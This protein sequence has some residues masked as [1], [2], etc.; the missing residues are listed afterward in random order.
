MSCCLSALFVSPFFII[1]GLI[2]RSLIMRSRRAAEAEKELADHEIIEIEKTAD[3]KG[4]ESRGGK[5]D[6]G[7]GCL[8]LTAHKLYFLLWMPK[9]ETEIYISAMTSVEQVDEF[10][11][12]PDKSKKKLL[13]VNFENDAGHPDSAAWLVPEIEKWEKAIEELIAK[14]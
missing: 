3:F 12:K 11:D 5:Q 13:Q 1:F 6:K 4:Q 8:A 10:M 14:R 7:K 9:V 2:F